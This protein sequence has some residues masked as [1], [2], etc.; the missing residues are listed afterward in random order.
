MRAA[1]YVP[2]ISP[3]WGGVW[4]YAQWVLREL[5]GVADYHVVGSRAFLQEAGAMGLLPDREDSICFEDFSE[6]VKATLDPSLLA[7]VDVSELSYQRLAKHLVD[8]QTDLIHVPIQLICEHAISSRFPYILNPHDYQHEHLPEFF[9]ESDINGRR[10]VW[11]PTQRAA[12]ALVVHS[13]Q[14][15]M[16]A[17]RFLDIP[18]ERVFYAPYGPM[19]TF[20]FVGP[21]VVAQAVRKFALPERYFFYPAR[22]W[23]H[24][25][26]VALVKAIAIL[27]RKGIDAYCVFTDNHSP[28][29]AVV[30]Q[31]AE[32]E[33]V[34]DH[35]VTV[36][37]VTPEEMSALYQASLMVVVPSLFEQ[38]SGPMLEAIQFEKPVAVSNLPELENTL[39][40]QGFI[41]DANSPTEIA[42]I[43][44]RFLGSDAL[45]STSIERIRALKARMSWAP[46]REVYQQAY[47]YVLGT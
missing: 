24:K 8:Q 37:R 27:K 36:G 10:N 42:E 19:K 6:E 29:A 21:D 33:G 12:S 18:E 46:F 40:G 41:F 30:E 7:G 20:D 22:M 1:L 43:L 25:N 44:D 23:P 35:I 14:T 3:D 17:I 34:V 26:H 47:D 39:D 5:A 13:K 9:S 15:Q 11:Y 2:T 4:Q 28:H 16:D 31:M 32:E 45:V 38:N